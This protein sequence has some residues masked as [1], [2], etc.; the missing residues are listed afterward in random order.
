MRILSIFFVTLVL[1][2]M[3]ISPLLAQGNWEDNSTNPQAWTTGNVGIGLQVPTHKLHVYQ[4]SGIVFGAVETAGTATSALKLINANQE[5]WLANQSSGDFRLRNNGL[6]PFVVEANTPS[7]TLVLKSAGYIGMGTNSPDARLEIIGGPSWTN[8]NYEKSLRL[9]SGDG[10][11]FNSSTG[12]YEKIGMIADEV[13]KT[14]KIFRTY[15]D[16]SMPTDPEGVADVLI[17]DATNGNVGIGA[18]APTEKFQVGGIVHSTTG[19]FKF[20]DGS[21]QTSAAVSATTAWSINSNDIYYNTGNV[22][23]GTSTPGALLTVGGAMK[24]T[25]TAN[26]LIHHQ[27][28]ESGAPDGDGFRIRYDESFLSGPNDYLVIEKTDQNQS[29]SPDGGIAFL[30]T[31]SDGGT[32]V[33]TVSL[34]IEGNGN[35]GVGTANPEALLTLDGAMK[36][37]NNAETLIHHQTNESGAPDGDGFRIRYDESFLSGPNDY[38]VIEKTDQ[39]QSPSPDGGIA[40]LNTTEDGG[41]L[42]ETVSLII[43]GNGNVGVGTSSPGEKF[44]VSGTVSSTTGGFKFPD[45]TVQTTAAT[46]TASTWTIDNNDIYYD[47]GNVGIGNNDPKTELH[48]SSSGSNTDV[49]RIESADGDPII[50]LTEFSGGQGLVDIKTASG[51]NAV[52]LSGSGTTYLDGGNVGIGTKSP[53]HLLTVDGTIKSEEIIVED[54]A[55]DFVF[56]DDYQLRSLTEVEEFVK[57]NKHLPEVPPAVEMRKGIGVSVMQTKLLQKVEELTLYLIQLE[58]ENKELKERVTALEK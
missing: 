57:K 15:N 39:N 28:N 52:R 9:S 29:P 17:V 6:N 43:E 14:F 7:S 53:T 55:A 1:S 36:F 45:G 33:E 19:G 30:N 40:F 13:S 4:S 48:I 27:T 18:S 37:T 3:A 54:V 23:I 22:G 31:T 35:I 12:T 5:W 8:Q 49:L 47:G 10:I 21:V 11:E 56:E 51:S 46:T 41:T 42:V 25:N 32:L 38:L 16:D 26:T 44:E 34:I 58:K 20:P 50:E 2:T 24:F